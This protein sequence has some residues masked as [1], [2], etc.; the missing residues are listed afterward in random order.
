MKHFH[1][2]M[3][4]LTIGCFIYS[5]YGILKNVPAPRLF[6][7]LSHV[8]YLLVVLTGLHLLWQ[9]SQVA[10]VQHWAYAKIVLL[11]VAI[12][13]MIKARKATAPNHAKAGVGIAFV[14]LIAIVGLALVKPVLGG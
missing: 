3:M 11:V 7:I 14:A 10:G 9:L 8:V 5:A 4:V 2:L 12:S 13:A 6:S 1:L